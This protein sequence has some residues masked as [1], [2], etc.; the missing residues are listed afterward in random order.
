MFTNSPVKRGHG[1]KA[2]KMPENSLFYDKILPILF[3]C[4]GIMM[5]L[6]VLFA[7]GVITGV[8]PWK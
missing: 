4:L 6:L 7:V 5:A 8:I 3:V 2:H 1:L